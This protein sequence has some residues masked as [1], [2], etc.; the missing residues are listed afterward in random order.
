MYEVVIAVAVVAAAIAGW[1]LSRPWTRSSGVFY[2][3]LHGK[4]G[5]GKCTLVKVGR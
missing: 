3:G 5:K 4:E 1:M 2:G